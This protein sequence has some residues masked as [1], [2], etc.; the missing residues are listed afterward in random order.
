MPRINPIELNQA[1][2]KS[3]TL[4]E[5]VKKALG[6]TPNLMRTLAHSPA[7]LEAY[8]GFGKALGSGKLSGQLREQIALAVSGVNAC[9]YCASAHTAAG[10]MFKLDEEELAANVQGRSSTPKTEAALQFAQKVV[11][12]RGWV[13]DED[14]RRLRDVGYSDAEIVEI[15][16]SVAMTTFSNYFNHIA[17]TEVDFPVVEVEQVTAAGA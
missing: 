6:F 4:L 8:L 13:E 1:D 17:E 10:K 3:K 14:V 9:Q 15:I 12:D 5:N 2:A 11:V 7:A 16:A